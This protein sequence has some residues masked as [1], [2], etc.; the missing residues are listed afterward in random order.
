MRHS[1][2]QRE[3]VYRTMINNAEDERIIRMRKS[4]LDK[5]IADFEHQ[6]KRLDETVRRVD[7]RTNLQVKGIL[8]V[9]EQAGNNGKD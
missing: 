5:W 3:A 2:H 7:I 8:H 6:K 1:F 4:Q 9:E